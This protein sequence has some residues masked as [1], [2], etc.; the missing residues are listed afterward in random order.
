ME[1][2]MERVQLSLEKPA[3]IQELP[4][5]QSHWLQTAIESTECLFLPLLSQGA[6]CSA[7]QLF[8]R[9]ILFY[10]YFPNDLVGPKTRAVN[11]DCLR[12]GENPHNGCALQCGTRVSH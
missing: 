7:S 1:I 2:G 3:F 10:I 9:R 5:V 12:L 11:C 8:T 6:V 4:L